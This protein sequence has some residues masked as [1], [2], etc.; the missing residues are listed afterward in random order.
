MSIDSAPS[1]PPPRL[2]LFKNRAPTH[3]HPNKPLDS[4]ISQSEQNL[5]KQPSKSPK[6]DR[7][8]Q[9][10][11]Q[12]RIRAMST[13]DPLPD[14]PVELTQIPV[15]TNK[16]DN[17]RDKR[18]SE[19]KSTFEKDHHLPLEH[20]NSIAQ[21][22]FSSFLPHALRNPKHHQKTNTKDEAN[23]TN[24]TVN[25]VTTNVSN[26]SIHFSDTIP[27]K[28]DSQSQLKSTTAPTN[29][30]RLVSSDSS[31]RLL[32]PSNEDTISSSSLF[33]F[34][35]NTSESRSAESFIF[36]SHTPLCVSEIYHNYFFDYFHINYSG[37]FDAEGPFIAS[38]RCINHKTA[39]TDTCE[40]RA[41][42]RTQY[43]NCDVSETLNST[44]ENSILRILFHKARLPSVQTYGPVGDPKANEKIYSFDKKNDERYNCKIGV[45]YQRFNQTNEYDIFNNDQPSN[46]MLNFLDRI[47]QRVNLKG[48]Q[49]YRGDLDTKNGSHGEHSYHAEYKNHEIMFN[50]A[51]L[52]PSTNADEKCTIRKGLIG[53]AFVCIVFQEQGAN[54]SPDFISGKV[55]QI[56]ITVQPII[57]DEKLH[58]K[59][60]MWRRNDITSIIDPPGGI[61]IYDKSFCSYFLTLLLNSVDVAIKSPSLR[62]RVYEQRQR[63]KYEDLQ[64]LCYVF[65][66]SPIPDFG[67]ELDNFHHVMDTHPNV[68]SASFTSNTTTTTTDT[69]S[70]SGRTSPVSSKKK[71]FSKK[72]FGVFSN[73][74]PLSPSSSSTS[75]NPLNNDGLS[76]SGQTLLMPG[77]PLP[78]GRTSIPVNK[79]NNHRSR[80]SKT[81][82][83]PIILNNS[84]NQK[85]S[86]HISVPSNNF[87][88]N[89][90]TETNTLNTYALGVAPRN[91][92]NS[93]PEDAV[94]INKSSYIQIMRTIREIW[95]IYIYLVPQRFS[96]PTIAEHFSAPPSEDDDTEEES[97][98]DEI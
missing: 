3:L 76:A 84:S 7:I 71:G 83:A 88:P 5:E 52:V 37:V 1:S 19:I 40:A 28:A 13:E 86:T 54:F 74:S 41:I 38:L 43:R 23:T 33:T 64:K 50:I 59:I 82:H 65:S 21:I 35:E 95:Y 75:P 55:T 57:K 29:A 25:N 30:S 6:K 16:S 61:L 31:E 90:S 8:R 10:R 15:L 48:F 85:L 77:A 58:Y 2:S 73:R 44:N 63:L 70:H 79:D 49:K 97:S 4:H 78:S 26:S 96:V 39:M 91:R 66:I 87:V 69:N 72:F 47:S 89:N 14:T 34:D 53:N 11:S 60:G 56:Y 67:S 80:S 81:S 32:L 22:H 62:S 36:E 98:E 93:S 42:I 9:H 92:S 94:N 51:P 18:T 45:I 27:M 24:F 68:R 12:L 46:E 20:R 17:K